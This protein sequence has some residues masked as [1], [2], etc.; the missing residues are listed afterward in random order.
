MLKKMSCWRS[1]LQN[2]SV[3]GDFD[4]FETGTGTSESAVDEGI[5]DAGESGGR[6]GGVVGGFEDLLGEETSI[7]H[8]WG[9]GPLGHAGG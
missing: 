5:A 3:S 1:I 6:D 7:V 8:S 2:L 9:P 4:S